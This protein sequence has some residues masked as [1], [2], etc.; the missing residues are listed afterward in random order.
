MGRSMEQL[1]KRLIQMGGYIFQSFGQSQGQGWISVGIAI[2]LGF[3]P[4]GVRAVGP[5]TLYSQVRV[6]EKPQITTR[7]VPGDQSRAA[8]HSCKDPAQ[9]K[10]ALKRRAQR[11]ER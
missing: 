5:F 2:V 3:L 10:R 9:I 1:L 11:Q 6:P 8:E 4:T 7:V